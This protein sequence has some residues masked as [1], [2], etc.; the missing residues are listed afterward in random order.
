[1]TASDALTSVDYWD[2][3][4]GPVG[5]RGHVPRIDLEAFRH[6]ARLLEL[7]RR[8]LAPGKRF[9]EIGVGGS[10][11]PAY[12]VQHLG[13]EAWG[14]DNSP[15]GIVLA[16]QAAGP[17]RVRLIEG[18]FFD[19]T[20]LPTGK[21]DVVYSGGFVEHFTDAARVMRRLRELVSPDGVV[22]TTVPNFR[23]LNG[24]LQRVAD[25]DTLDRHV[26]Y[27][28]AMLDTA[29]ESGGLEPIERAHYEGILDIAS[30]DV[31]KRLRG[32]PNVVRRAWWIGTTRL[33]WLAERIARSMGRSTGGGFLAPAVAGVY[34][35]A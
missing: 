8:Y 35:R 5:E 3:V 4:W 14:I 29:H 34:R 20:L 6:Q 1:M 13:V 7:F 32:L 2:R 9:I 10:A 11:W 33:R 24:L 25:R 27:D 30:V 18:D 19:A 28:P 12:L 31:D 16:K 26:L 21:F 15:S 23:G 22:I 17:V